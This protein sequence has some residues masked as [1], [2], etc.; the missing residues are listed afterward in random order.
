[1]QLKLKTQNLFVQAK[2]GDESKAQIDSSDRNA[3]ISPLPRPTYW[4]KIKTA[5]R[6]K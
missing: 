5:E 4:A 6:S 2:V 1:M 3:S